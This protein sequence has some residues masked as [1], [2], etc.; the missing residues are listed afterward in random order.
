VSDGWNPT[1]SQYLQP[2]LEDL[3][4]DERGSMCTAGFLSQVT[5]NCPRLKS[6]AF[7]G[8]GSRLQPDEFLSFF[9]ANCQLDVIRLNLS[10]RLT[11]SFLITGDL[12]LHLSRMPKLNHLKLQNPLD[13]PE[14][15]QKIKDQNDVPFRNL[16]M[17]SLS[18]SAQ[19]V[20]F[21]SAS[22]RSQGVQPSLKLV[23][24]CISP[25][26]LDVYRP[27]MNSRDTPTRRNTLLLR[28][29]RI[30]T[31]VHVVLTSTTRGFNLA[32]L[33]TVASI[34]FVSALLTIHQATSTVMSAAVHVLPNV[35]KLCLVLQDGNGSCF[36]DLIAMPSLRELQ[37]LGTRATSF[38][39]RDL[40][41]LR[42]LNRLQKLFILP[43]Y[44]P[45]Q[46]IMTAPQ[47]TDADFDLMISGLPNLEIFECDVVWGPRS[48]AIL[49][50]LSKNCP[51]LEKLRLGGA[52]D[53]QTLNNIPT[54]L[55]PK[56]SDLVLG[57]AE[58][59]G[60]R[61]RLTPLQIGRLIDHH[62]PALEDLLFTSDEDN[63]EHPVMLAWQ[64]LSDEI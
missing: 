10:P 44:L 20:S 1:V 64:N 46:N 18:V 51:K 4:L 30:L 13:Q 57:D 47:V 25:K 14:S 59:Q 5:E 32:C 6:I 50:S 23:T 41:A 38:A 29:L 58:I 60:I 3:I 8:V 49:S 11:K 28:L 9:Q 42:D 36:G 35:V 61:V 21:V 19:D 24:L 45:D 55:F 12:L 17:V 39:R 62:A 33:D 43:Q 53:L 40:L 52:F 22:M 2:A 31:A 26:R 34:R 16:T 7:T 54:V 63:L 15:F 56:L 37:I 27:G 48:V